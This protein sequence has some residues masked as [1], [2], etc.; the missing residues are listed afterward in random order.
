[1]NRT[2]AHWTPNREFQLQHILDW[3]ESDATAAA[4]CDSLGIYQ[5][6]DHTIDLL[7]SDEDLINAIKNQKGHAKN[8]NKNEKELYGIKRNSI[9]AGGNNRVRD[10]LVL[11]LALDNDTIGTTGV[12]TFTSE[13]GCGLL[14]IDY[15]TESEVKHMKAYQ[16]C[17]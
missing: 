3:I 16:D 7:S 4:I 13:N 5:D 8:N 10:I 9:L 6:I 15:Y 14:V 1:M 17:R 12:D 2:Y 11:V